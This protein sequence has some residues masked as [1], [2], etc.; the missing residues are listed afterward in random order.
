[1]MAE[2]N[3]GPLSTILLHKGSESARDGVERQR[4]GGAGGQIRAGTEAMQSSYSASFPKVS[5][6]EQLTASGSGQGKPLKAFQKP[7]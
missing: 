1:M 4:E 5:Q 3:K 6:K 2:V 7:R